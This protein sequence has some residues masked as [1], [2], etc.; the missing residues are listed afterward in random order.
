V[1]IYWGVEVWVHAFLT[2]VLDGGEWSASNPSHFT[3]KGKNPWYP[4]D[5]LSG[6]QNQPRHNGKEKKFP[7]PARS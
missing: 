5:R 1:K 2:S 4:L 3:P 7:S 6:P